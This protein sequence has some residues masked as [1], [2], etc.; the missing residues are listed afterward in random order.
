M[1]SLMPQLLE[2]PPRQR[3]AM[4]GKFYPPDELVEI[5]GLHVGQEGK[6][7]LLERLR[8]GGGVP[9]VHRKARSGARFAALFLDML[10][11]F[12]FS[13]VLS[14]SVHA[15]STSLYG[16]GS[17]GA[18][19]YLNVRMGWILLVEN[20]TLLIYFALSHQVFGRTLGKNSTGLK[21]ITVGGGQL[22]AAAA[23]VRS[24]AFLGP[25][26]IAP[27]LYFSNSPLLIIRAA[28]GILWGY[29]LLDGL[30]AL[31]DRNSGRA[32]HDR[33]AGSRVVEANHWQQ[34][35]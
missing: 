34:P 12:S 16:L 4:T 24:L 10:L 20:L 32:L 13:A 2:P 15:R 22:T 29:L 27:V 21:V 5:S 11:P 26:L 8:S 23:W 17:A 9:F 14:L 1:T 19:R 35:I 6:E 31:L 7:L 3:C 28:T 33:L 18:A 30:V 25:G